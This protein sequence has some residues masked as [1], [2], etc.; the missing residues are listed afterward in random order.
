MGPHGWVW[1]WQVKR[2]WSSLVSI[3][4]PRVLFAARWACP[5]NSSGTRVTSQCGNRFSALSP[6]ALSPFRIT[7][8][9]DNPSP[10]TKGP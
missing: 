4:S 9:K 3:E 5:S 10:S 8:L 6:P 7:H 2:G 1:G